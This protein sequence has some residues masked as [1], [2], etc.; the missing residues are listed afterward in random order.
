MMNFSVTP[1]NVACLVVQV[2]LLCGVLWVLV[3]VRWLRSP[4]APVHLLATGVFSCLLLILPAF[5][6]P[7]QFSWFPQ[8]GAQRATPDSPPARIDNSD[9]ESNPSRLSAS[10]AAFDQ[11]GPLSFEKPLQWWWTGDGTTDS[12][13]SQGQSPGALFRVLGCIWLFVTLASLCRVG[14]GLLGLARLSRRASDPSD[15][16]LMAA[17]DR[18]AP[19]GRR[20]KLKV[21]E[22]SLVEMPAIFGCRRSV[23]L[24]PGH[25]RDWS[26]QELAAALAHELAHADQH[27]FA[28]GLMTRIVTAVYWW[29]PLVRLASGELRVQQEIRA[30]AI[31][32]HGMRDPS[33]YVRCISRLAM[34]DQ[35]QPT[36]LPLTF[37][38]GTHSLIRRIKAMKTRKNPL[39]SNR[40]A[41]TWRAMTIPVGIALAMTAVAIGLRPDSSAAAANPQQAEPQQTETQQ[42][43]KEMASETPNPT[44]ASSSKRPP[45]H[46]TIARL[47]DNHLDLNPDRIAG[48][49]D[50]A[51]LMQAGRRMMYQQPDR[52]ILDR[53]VPDFS[54]FGMSA[55]LALVH[56]RIA[57]AYWDRENKHTNQAYRDR[58][59]APADHSLADRH[60]FVFFTT[61]DEL[62]VRGVDTRWLEDPANRQ[63]L[64]QSL[65]IF[66]TVEPLDPSSD[67]VLSDFARRYDQGDR[68]AGVRIGPETVKYVQQQAIA[69]SIMDWSSAGSIG[70][71]VMMTAG[72]QECSVELD[73][74]EPSD[75]RLT[76]RMTGQFADAESAQ[77]FAVQVDQVW[78]S[79]QTRLTAQPLGP[80]TLVTGHD[81]AIATVEM[82]VDKA[83]AMDRLDAMIREN[84]PVERQ[85]SRER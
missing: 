3:A 2:S 55:R 34:H 66:G 39:G 75:D 85:A 47:D 13:P 16:R 49:D 29:N 26:D 71:M 8:K 25:W 70:P 52:P 23:L 68:F 83:T 37:G 38:W 41:M 81:G 74:G 19:E 69:K 48:R 1:T 10:E 46:V 40:P 51:V 32:S 73:C 43:E 6:S 42:P 30:D 18:I 63:Q 33:Q 24:L 61:T 12:F 53:V 54:K 56:R 11:S 22:T 77:R 79:I 60:S 36:P 50:L 78:R 5:W 64:V 76:I 80:V 4:S 82:S 44:Q 62:K 59:N 57:D 27:D 31:A 17:L 15:T 35:R 67:T 7:L 14:A 45:I 58:L 9:I 28:I 72:L 65:G 84:E 20:F 21:L